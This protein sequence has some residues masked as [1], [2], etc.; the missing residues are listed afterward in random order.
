LGDGGWGNTVV[1]RILPTQL[2]SGS[3]FHRVRVPVQLSARGARTPMLQ[4]SDNPVENEKQWRELPPIADYQDVGSLRLAAVSLLNI[5]VGE[6]VQPL[7]V[8]QPYGRGRTMILATG[9]TWRWR[10]GLPYQDRRQQEFWRQLARALVTDVPAAFE[11]SAHVQG[12]DVRVRAEVRDENFE[13]LQNASVQASVSALSG[14]SR[15][16]LQPVENEP[17]VYEGTFKP[18]SSGSL[19]IEAQ[20]QRDGKTLNAA[21]TLVHFEQGDAEYFSLRQNRGV[22][23]RLAQSTGGRYWRADDLTGLPEAIR[24]SS[25]GVAQQEILPLWNAPAVF[26]LLALLKCGEWLLRRRWGVV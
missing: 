19:V 9:G 25:A 24:A 2:P 26:L 23:E 6:R 3:S 12:A 13:P 8:S 18:D 14:V 4:F 22:L 16:T 1:G 21:R 11:L 5:K 15:L 10:M 17:G 20:A 7:L